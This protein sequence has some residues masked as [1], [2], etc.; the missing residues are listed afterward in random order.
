MHMSS[1]VKDR[2]CSRGCQRYY[3]FDTH[4][5]EETQE[6]RRASARAIR[7]ME[8]AELRRVLVDDDHDFVTPRF[9]HDWLS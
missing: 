6:M 8:R 7:R 4:N 1:K 2:R 5:S 3:R 9:G